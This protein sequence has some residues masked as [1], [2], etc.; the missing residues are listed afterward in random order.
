MKK[1]FIISLITSVIT[2]FL[3][4]LLMN[5]FTSN[6]LK[7][8]NNFSFVG[9]VIRNVGDGWNAIKDDGHE[10]VGI[11]KVETTNEA[12]I[13]YYSKAFKVISLNVTPDETMAAEGYTMGASVGLDKTII[14]VY[15]KNHNL[16][17]PNE[18]TNKQGN[19]WV[20]GVFI[21]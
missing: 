12:I 13:I 2:S 17:D 7:I 4:V 14:N 6:E 5:N 3:V 18:Y 8:N 10:P 9:G 21:K 20:N 16:I 19:I 15:D 11:R 1:T